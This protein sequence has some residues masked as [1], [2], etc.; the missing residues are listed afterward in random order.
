VFF[1]LLFRFVVTLRN[2]LAV[3]TICLELL[4]DLVVNLVD[5]DVSIIRRGNGGVLKY[6]VVLVFF[7]YYVYWFDD[8]LRILL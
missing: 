2:N 5:L 6:L 7:F 1:F 3:L 4:T 8:N